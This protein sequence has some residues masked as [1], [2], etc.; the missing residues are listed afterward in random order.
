MQ[1]HMTKGPLTSSVPGPVLFGPFS[2]PSIV[3]M[4]CVALEELCVYKKTTHAGLLV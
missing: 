2:N 3:L 4:S 1:R